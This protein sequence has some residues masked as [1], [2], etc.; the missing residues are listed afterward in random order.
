M[1][2]EQYT[3][4]WASVELLVSENGEIH[5][6]SGDRYSGDGDQP[7]IGLERIDAKLKARELMVLV[8]QCR[9][10]KVIDSKELLENLS[11][12]EHERWSNWMRWM[13]DNET[14]KNVE[15]WKKQMRTPYADLSDREKE[16]DRKEARKTLDV[17]RDNLHAEAALL[18]ATKDEK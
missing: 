16:S 9:Y 10:L 15:R 8:E 11:A 14:E 6:V 13:Y 5:V 4:G 1:N 17:L 18:V 12:L 3:T 7:Y 2:D